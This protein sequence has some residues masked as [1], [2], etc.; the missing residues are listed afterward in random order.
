MFALL[1]GPPGLL[2]CCLL[3]V[4]LPAFLF[5]GGSNNSLAWA[6][7]CSCEHGCPSGTKVQC[8]SLLEKGSF[9]PVLYCGQ[10]SL[11]FIPVQR[12]HPGDFPSFKNG[13]LVTVFS[14]RSCM[15]GK[16]KSIHCL[17]PFP[18]APGCCFPSFPFG[19]LQS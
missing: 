4:R 2:S 15:G 16:Y 5:L 13:G 17:C 6:A 8:G 18:P 9:A 19:P 14:P 12:L 3:G 10:E 11:L 7:G 1:P